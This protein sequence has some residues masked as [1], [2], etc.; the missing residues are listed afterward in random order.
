[1]RKLGS[2][3]PAAGPEIA[4]MDDA[5]RLLARGA[6]G[7]L[8]IRGETVT[9]GYEGDA[10]A[11]AAVFVDGWFRTGD[12]GCIDDD[13]YV[14]VTGRLEEL[15]NRGGEKIAPRE[16]EEALLR[17][18]ALAQA[19]AFAVPHATL[20]EDVESLGDRENQDKPEHTTTMQSAA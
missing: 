13:G 7:E 18:P 14:V 2:V 17:D 19:V 4:V 6:V 16:V 15:I 1:M 9:T 10:A 20:G 3:G 5:G 12:Q 8:V 11:N